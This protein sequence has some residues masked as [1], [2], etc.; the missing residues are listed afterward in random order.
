MKLA[1]MHKIRNNFMNFTEI[2][3]QEGDLYLDCEKII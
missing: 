3:T 2:V 1:K